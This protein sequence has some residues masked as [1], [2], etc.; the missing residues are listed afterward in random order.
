[1]K[2]LVTGKGCSTERQ[3]LEEALKRKARPEEVQVAQQDLE[4]AVAELSTKKA[5]GG[6]FDGGCPC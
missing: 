4:V 2:F 3:A 5:K 1:M 6:Q